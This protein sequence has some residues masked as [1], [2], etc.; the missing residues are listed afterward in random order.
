MPARNPLQFYDENMVLRDVAIGG[1]KIPLAKVCEKGKDDICV[2]VVTKKK[3]NH[4]GDAYIS[5][6]FQAGISKV[7]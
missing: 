7:S 5:L 3:G 2:P 4:R 6:T 1:C